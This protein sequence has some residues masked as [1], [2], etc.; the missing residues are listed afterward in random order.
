MLQR[1]SN[2]EKQKRARK[3]RTMVIFISFSFFHRRTNRL[4]VCVISSIF[5]PFLL[6]NFRYLLRIARSIYSKRNQNILHVLICAC[7]LMSILCVWKGN[8]RKEI[9]FCVLL[10]CYCFYN[11]T[12]TFLACAC[13]E[14]RMQTCNSC[15]IAHAY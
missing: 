8:Y 1:E 3:T 13:E 4:Y 10:W 11:S 7:N 12:H 6:Q 15:L 14:V 5:P 2:N 9:F